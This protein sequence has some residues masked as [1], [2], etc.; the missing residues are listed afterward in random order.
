MSHLDTAYKLG[1]LKAMEDF[2]TELAK[3]AFTPGQST[4]PANTNV[5]VGSAAEAVR[6]SPASGLGTS[7]RAALKGTQLP[8][9]P[10]PA[11]RAQ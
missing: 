5:G 6:G 7:S 9:N 4:P 2:Q 8:V 10:P 1:A 11:Q 3:Q